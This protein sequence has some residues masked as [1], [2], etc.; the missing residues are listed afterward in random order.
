MI[1]LKIPQVGDFMKAFLVDS[2]FD[3]FCI[4]SG[5]VETFASFSIDGTINTDFYSDD[6]K[7][8]LSGRKA[9]LWSEIKPFAYSLMKGR[10]LPVS[11]KFTL[12][13][14][15]E[16]TDWLLDR[17]QLNAY[18]E[19]LCGLYL[20]IRY[21]SHELSC[22]TGLSY[23]TFVMDKRLEQLWDDTARQFLRQ[24]RVAFEENP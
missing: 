7:E 5:E 21:R 11:F 3:S 2:V 1:A 18:K 20:N 13:L 24:N 22:V 4:C 16:N 15:Q 9:A 23:S 17:Y 6:E 14:S 8:A 12:Q 19:Q 10:N